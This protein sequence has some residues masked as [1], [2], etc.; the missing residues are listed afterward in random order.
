M[1]S[2][3]PSKL[4]LRIAYKNREAYLL[5]IITLSI[6]LACAILITLFSLNEFGFDRFHHDSHAVFRVLQHNNAAAYSGNRLSNNIPSNVFLSIQSHSKDSVRSSRVKI[7][8]D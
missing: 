2:L 4:F 1:M 3:F 8:N 6:T 7:M 5:K